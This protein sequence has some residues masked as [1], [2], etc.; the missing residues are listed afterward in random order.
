MKLIFASLFVLTF[1]FSILAQVYSDPTYATENDSII[2]YFDATQGDQGMMGYTGTDVYAHTGVITN[3]STSP[4]DWK[5]VVAPWNVNIPKA[6]LSR[7]ATD[8]YKLVIGFPRIY[9]NLT[10]PNEKIL[11]LAFVF[12]NST[13][14]VTGRAVGGAD[15][16]LDLYEPGITVV[17]LSPEVNL[18]FGDPRRSPLFSNGSDTIVVQATAAPIG[19]EVQQMQV[20][21][22]QNLVHEVL[23][24]TIRYDFI[25]ANFGTGFQEIAVVSEDTSGITDTSAFM[26]MIN[27]PA[28]NAP[29]PPGVVDGINYQDASTVIVSLFAPYKDFVYVIGDFNNWLVD[30]LY[31]MNREEINPD[32]VRYWITLDGLNP[33]EEYAFQYLVE[34]DL[35][36]ADPYADKILDPFNDPYIPSSIYPNL[37]SYP[38]GK[39]SEIVSV[40]QTDQIPFSWVYSDTFQRPEKKD[41]VIYEMLVR[42]FLQKHDYQTL[43][44]TLGY[45]KDLG[46]NAIELMPFNEFEGNSSWGYNPS[47]YFAPD[48]YYGPKDDLKRF[49]DECHRH[50]IAV[51]QDIVLNHAYGQCSLV[52]LYWNAQNNR[53]SAQNPWFNQVSPN[54]VFSWGNDFNHES[55]ATRIFVDRVNTYW[56]TEY[57]IDGFRFDFTKGFTNTPG[58]GSNFDQARI[59]ILK[60]MADKIWEVDTTA[61]IILEHFA[62][63]SEEK[64]LA[65]YSYGMML[66]GNMNYNYNE[67]TMGYH[68]GG[69][70][71]FSWGYYGNRTWTKPH[72]VTYMESHDEERLMY[73]NVTYGNS[74]GAYSIQDTLTALQRMQL[75]GAFFFT[76][77]GPK[78]IWQFGELGYDYSIDYNGRIGEKPIRWD[79]LSQ[80]MRE[81]LFKTFG[82]LLNLRHENELFTSPET[83]VEFWLNDPSGKKRIRLMHPSMNATI[84][85]N[86]GVT[87]Q[88]IDPQFLYPGIWYDYFSGDSL[89]VGGA[90]LTVNLY[91]G[92][93]FIYTDVKLPTPEP[94][95]LVGLV[96][97]DSD[98]SSLTFQLMQNYP[99][100]FNPVTTIEFI[101]PLSG[102]IT[103]KIFN[104]LGEEVATLVSGE[105]PAG[106]YRYQWDT[107][108]HAGIASGFY[109]FQLKAVSR[110]QEFSQTRRMLLLK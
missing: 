20:L 17:I 2:V 89:T 58:D 83:N 102:D 45:L 73:K 96:D 90:G 71:D 78:M 67:A 48:K 1:S 12:R 3:Y 30:P 37:K 97:K 39:T 76:Y 110:E 14:T 26:V 66:W 23:D 52:R 82:A 19:T 108:R 27:P 41:L 85:G 43:I 11:Q 104:V 16:F 18:S 10:D 69:K 6:K 47:F 38:S 74:S 106:I 77:P 28:P 81:K 75:V 7:I 84:V 8:L 65:E 55:M 93:F 105:L 46:V 33:G 53:P 5:H 32:S 79:Y 92:Q 54:P 4:S 91:P 9:Y 13:A 98:Q 22:N 15:I 50:G 80:S 60:R 56:L 62:P 31:Y 70:S 42:D 59:N 68:D 99:N 24:D 72:L 49:I 63:N 36:I 61:Y 57:K 101:L 64:I 86:F 29:V 35:R 88:S 95:L 87:T 107:S 109:F 94:G 103:L 51:I 21:V 44:D 25:S 40:F 34:G 100:P